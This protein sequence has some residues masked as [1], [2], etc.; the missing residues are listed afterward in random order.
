MVILPN[1]S[2]SAAKFE[3]G[4][5]MIAKNQKPTKLIR[6]EAAFDSSN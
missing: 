5:K 2:A 4:L 1:L 6:L 3:N